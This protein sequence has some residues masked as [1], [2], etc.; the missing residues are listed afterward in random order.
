MFDVF[1][2]GRKPGLFAHEQSADSIEHARQLSRTRYFWI[3]NYLSDYS[4]WD[5]LW[6]PVPWEA[7]QMHAWPS[8]WQKDSGTYLVPKEPHTAVNYHTAPTVIRN[9]ISE[10]WTNTDD[11]FDYTWHPDPTD[12]LYI[13]QF[14][15]QW[16]KTGG[17]CYIV[18]G[19]TE[20][21]YVDIA[22]VKKKTI[23]PNW[24]VDNS[25][26][27]EDFD[28]TWH[29]DSTDEPYIYQ[30]GTQWQKTG[31]PKYIVPGA[32]QIKYVP[33]PRAHRIKI[34]DNWQL[35]NGTEFGDF[36][37]TWHPDSTDQPY[38][39]QFGTQ[40]QKTGGPKY[41]TPGAV[42]VKYVEQ[43]KIEAKRV[44]DCVFLLDHLDGNVE[45]VKEQL[46]SKFESI[47]VVRYFDNYLDTLR[48]IA[49][50]ASKQ[51]GFIWICSSLCDYTN[52]DFSWHPE[53]WQTGM[54]H[55]FP[56]NEQ[57]FGDTFFMQPE[58]FVYRSETCQLLEWFDL[59]FVSDMSVPRLPLPTI[60]HSF[61]THVD[62]VKTKSWQG[63]LAIFTIDNFVS[64]EKLPTVALWRKKT[65]TIV[66]TSAGSSTVIVP[67]VAIPDIKN[68][69]YDYEFVDKSFSN[70]LKD[71]PLDIVFI[72]NGEPNAEANWQH[73]QK[74][75]ST[76]SN[77]LT[78]V[79]GINGR[80]AAYKAAAEASETPWFFSVFAK[81]EIDPGFDFAWQPDRMQQAKHYIFYSQN[82]INGLE[83]GHQG[84]IAYNKKLVMDT[85][86]IQ[87]LDFTL[88]QPHGVEPILSGIAHFNTDAWNTW[89]TTFREVVKLK[90]Y[91]NESGDIET[92]YRL[93]T[94]Q[95]KAQGDYA[96]WCL[97]GAKDAVDYYDAVN[98]NY[99]DLLL[100]FEWAWLRQ[101]FDSKYQT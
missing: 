39:Y 18:P 99:S 25:E 86:E 20:I 48:R 78:R 54:L 59:N 24:Q 65:K 4:G 58:S 83:Y 26:E 69:M 49:K 16:Q 11:V 38:I 33:S 51:T 37:Y 45:R 82:P 9:G 67:S 28:Y 13:Y 61:D 7:N 52:F 79:D 2:I 81:L 27:F 35:P 92:D 101:Y 77:R 17:P 76:Q 40:W 57:K 34:D 53:Q 68:Q 32:T 74:I 80:S 97:R 5:W 41:V 87:G 43:I 23:D 98:G 8:Q 71:Q 63:P 50:S 6:E 56:S 62:A 91:V 75:C 30:F 47:K 66:T 84:L 73:L 95:T 22:R 19:A 3:V 88:S 93:K 89:R 85:E 46:K 70:L 44:A 21:K 94:W 15:T 10:Y 96:E 1:Y 36:D 64:Q 29:P 42:D 31:G 14:G 12:P 60:Q 55:V 90:H 72:S 100:T